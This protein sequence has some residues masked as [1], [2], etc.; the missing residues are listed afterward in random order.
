[1]E[2]DG[3]EAALAI[4]RGI[5]AGMTHIDTAEMYGDGE[6]EELVGRAITGRRSEV[7][8]ASKVLPHHASYA[9]TREACEASLARLRTDVLDLYLL[10]WR[11]P[12]PL[13][14]TLRALQE[15]RR[16]GKIRAFGVSNF[17]VADLEEAL[18]IVGEGQLACNQVLYHLQERHIE[19]AVI[20]WCR[21]HGVGVV[22][23]S[24]FGSGQFPGPRSRGGGVLQEIAAARDATPRQV[25]LAFL[26][27]QPEVLLIPKASREEHVLENARAADLALSAGEVRRI[28]RAF[29]VGDA[30]RGLPM[31]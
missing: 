6:V 3:P 1:M 26:L 31:I 9:G 21:A 7:Q 24:P 28:E 16:E 25:A 13:E 17:D 18:A 19:H 5:D 20:P 27:R 14:E 4:R 22:G 15:L 12:H 10:H 2:H 29:P 23:Y 11:G 8:L 30:R